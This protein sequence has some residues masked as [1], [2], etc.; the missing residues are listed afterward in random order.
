MTADENLRSGDLEAAR[1]ELVATLKRAPS[2]QGARMYLFQLLCVCGEWDKAAAQLRTLAQFSPEAQ[3]LAT[4][5]GQ[6]IEAEKVRA[7]AFA[8]TGAFPMLAGGD[9]AWTVDLAASLAASAAGRA[10]EAEALRDAAFSAASDTP[11]EADGQ[12]FG[13]VADADGRFG[14]VLEMVL[15]GRWGLM[16]FEVVET[17][18]F[19]PVRDLRDLVWRPVQIRLRTGLSTAAFVLAR[20]PGSENGPA[21]IRLGRETVWQAA[22]GE[23]R[24]LGQRLLSFDAGED[25]GVLSATTISIGRAH[26]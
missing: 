17:L 25:V 2:D 6:A 8:G 21:A 16:P 15:N 11:G 23:E 24:A 5:Y 19:E 10:D 9:L 14:P 18:A 1:A 20:Y 12:P 13:W 22:D 4:V 7:A 3:M 26:G